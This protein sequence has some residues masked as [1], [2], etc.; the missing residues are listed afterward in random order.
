M[1]GL[2]YNVTDP[3]V[4]TKWEQAL[5]RE[6]RPYD[7]LL[8]PASGLAGKGMNSLVQHRD[9]LTNGG[10]TI[11]IKIRYQ[12]EGR[13]RQGDEVLKG[14]EEGYKTNTQ[15]ISVDTIRHAFNIS[16]PI[17]QQWISE[18]AMAEGR[19]GLADWAARRLSLSLHAHAAGISS[20]TDNA[21]ALHNTINAINT[22]GTSYILRPNDRASDD[23]LTANDDF[24]ID[25]LN[26]L[27]QRVTM[28]R[29]K[30]RPAQTPWGPKYCMFISPEQ[31][32]S[33]KKSDSQWYSAMESSLQGGKSSGIFTRALGQFDDFLLFVSDFVPPGINSSGDIVANT[34]RAWVGG[35]GAL[36]LAYGR[37]WK[38]APGFTL[39][40][41]Q[42]V[43]ESEDYNHQNAIAV[44]SI[45]GASRLRFTKP[46]ESHA[47]EN[48]VLVLATYAD[49]DGVAEADAYRDWT[50]AG[51]SIA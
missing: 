15:D 14:N 9:A 38:V 19:D 35:A 33:L 50:D 2:A 18:D 7:P 41:W 5:E 4:V 8:D 51:L 30:I 44:A 36:T 43:R 24:D 49:L 3:E 21:F 29:P 6:I 11:R 16:S 17:Q 13:G 12:L 45:L 23:V 42:W 48:G 47:R 22:T 27:A 1:G 32:A 40:R 26:R 46:G 10:G 25:Q 31:R 20:I 39:N 28:V 37:G 34:R